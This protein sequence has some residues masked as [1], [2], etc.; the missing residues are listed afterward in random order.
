MQQYGHNF[1]DKTKKRLILY[2]GECS[3]EEVGNARPW[4]WSSAMLALLGGVARNGVGQH[5]SSEILRDRPSHIVEDLI[6][7]VVLPQRQV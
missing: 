2:L 7:R 3:T 4:I 5:G 1:N 6:L